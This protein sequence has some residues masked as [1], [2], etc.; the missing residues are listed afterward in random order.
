MFDFYKAI[1]NGAIIEI[2]PHRPEM[3]N[4]AGAKFYQDEKG[5]VC[6]ENYYIGRCDIDSIKTPDEINQHFQNMIE[7]HFQ[8][9]ITA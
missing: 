6:S 9:I 7:E 1:K 2:K 5:H 4:Y 3:M 8:I